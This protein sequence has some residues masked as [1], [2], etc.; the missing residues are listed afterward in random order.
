MLPA[1]PPSLSFT[2]SCA[3]TVW[4]HK[5][6]SPH[7]AA[8]AAG[9]PFLGKGAQKVPNR[10]TATRFSQKRVKTGPQAGRAADDGLTGR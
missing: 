9:C 3:P 6:P 2:L 5:L 7:D 4:A 8:A 1:Y 10:R